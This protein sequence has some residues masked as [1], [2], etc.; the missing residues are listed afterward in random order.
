MLIVLLFHWDMSW[1][2]WFSFFLKCGGTFNLH[3][4]SLYQGRFSSI[5]SWHTFLFHF[6]F[7]CS[8]LR[9][10][11]K[12]ILDCLCVFLVFISLWD[13]RLSSF[14]CDISSSLST[15]FRIVFSQIH[16][17][18]FSL[19][20]YLDLTVTS[21]NAFCFAS[22][23]EVNILNGRWYYNLLQILKTDNIK[24]K[25]PIVPPTLKKKNRK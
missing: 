11:I 17:I 9:A 20:L 19:H 4:K 13:H 3:V 6:F 24:R 8:F 5:I 14:F 16:L 2:W 23:R 25:T 18:L 1:C 22:A 15:V 7:F 12:Y 10:P 21:L